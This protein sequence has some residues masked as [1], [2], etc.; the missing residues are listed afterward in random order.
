MRY[1]TVTAWAKYFDKNEG[2]RISHATI[3]DRLSR[4]GKT[5]KT[6]RNR[7]GRI[8]VDAFYSESD[9]REACADLLMT[10]EVTRRK[11]KE[12]LAL[13][14]IYDRQSLIH[15]GTVKFM[16]TDFPPFRKGKAFASVVLG[17]T[18]YDFTLDHLRRIAN[19]LGFP[20]LSEKETKQQYIQA[21]ALHGIHDRQSLIRFRQRKFTR[22]D[23]PPFGKGL[24]F[25]SAILGETVHPLTLD[26]LRRIADTLFGE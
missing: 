4:A 5:A 9:V 23:F 15:F 18:V 13:H 20:E 17:E 14:G 3:R 21:L 1:G 7:F 12:A 10:V 19:A 25:A 22:T 26:H 2:I 24:A 11:A 6:F 16:K 8:L